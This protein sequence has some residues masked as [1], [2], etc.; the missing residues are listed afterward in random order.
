MWLR[1]CLAALLV[2]AGTASRTSDVLPAGPSDAVVDAAKTVVLQFLSTWRTAWLESTDRSG[3]ALTEIRLRDVHCHW[4]GSFSANTGR[5]NY[6]PPSLI[7]HSSRRS[8]CPN[9]VPSG[10]QAP[11]D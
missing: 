5:S 11:D 1:I 8:M 2:L 6:R 9:W 4:D 7:H 10:E 3:Y